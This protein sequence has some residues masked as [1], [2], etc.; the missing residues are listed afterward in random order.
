MARHL[1]LSV[2]V[3]LFSLLTAV[4]AHCQTGACCFADLACQVL[5]EEQC[6]AAEGGYWAEGEACDPNPC[7]EW[8]AACCLP[9]GWECYYMTEAACVEKG[10]EWFGAGTVCEP[11]P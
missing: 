7:Y 9:P 8:I 11:N 10:G 1:S 2:A 4:P 6:A 5:T 3:A